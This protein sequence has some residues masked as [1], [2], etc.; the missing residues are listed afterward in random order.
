MTRQQILLVD[1]TEAIHQ[2][3]RARLADEPLDVH[4]ALTAEQGLA[5]AVSRAPDVILLDVD[6]PGGCDGFEV[7]RRLKADPKTAGIPV[8]L[9]TG[10]RDPEQRLHGLDLGALDYVIKP[11]DAVELRARVRA[12]LRVKH[13]M[14][15]LATRAMIDG[16]TGLWNAAGLQRRL[17]AELS[18]STRSGRPL[19]FLVVDLDDFR[20]LN[21]AHGHRFG[22]E[23]LRAVARTIQSDCRAEDVVCRHGADALAMLLPN[24]T[25]EQ[26]MGPAERLRE[27]VARIPFTARGVAVSVTAS[28][29][30]ADNVD[31]RGALMLDIADRAVQQARKAGGNCSV[32]GCLPCGS[33]VTQ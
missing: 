32:N 13:L 8:V 30:V 24:S 6:I 4:S 12:A 21:G 33:A 27:A 31:G 15:L 20:Q 26:A 9:L 25:A 5:L 19:A 29:G 17:D 28:I 1:D 16:L 2:L 22:D 10:V 18:L 3:V 23:V 14:D 11:F 7:C